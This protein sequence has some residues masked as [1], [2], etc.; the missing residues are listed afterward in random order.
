MLGGSPSFSKR[1]RRDTNERSG[2]GQP[3]E[4]AGARDRSKSVDLADRMVS[5]PSSQSST[6]IKPELQLKVNAAK[7]DFELVCHVPH[8]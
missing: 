4:N 6:R 1:K 7:G 2:S 5:H 8:T 3:S